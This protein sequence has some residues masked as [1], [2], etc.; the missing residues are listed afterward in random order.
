MGAVGWEL[1]SDSQ[2]VHQR[3]L[4]T[5]PQPEWR[6]TKTFDVPAKLRPR[7]RHD[8]LLFKQFGQ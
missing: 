8:V 5:G 1:G 3:V 2:Q 7:A 6:D 4:R